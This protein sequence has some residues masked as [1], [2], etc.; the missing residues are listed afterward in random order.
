LLVAGCSGLLPG[1]G[2]LNEV[3][4]NERNEVTLPGAVVALVVWSGCAGCS[5]RC[6]LVWFDPGARCSGRWSGL[7]QRYRALW[8]RWWSG[9]QLP[10][11]GGPVWSPRCAGDATGRCGLV[12]SLRWSGLNEVYRALWSRWLRLVWLRYRALVVTCCSGLVWSGCSLLVARCARCSG[13]CG[14]VVR[15]GHLVA[16]VTL[17]GARCARC[18]GGLVASERALPVAGGPVVAFSAIARC[19]SSH[20]AYGLVLSDTLV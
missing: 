10:V 3:T 9:D 19:R 17:P 16:L 4:S 7:N 15:S 12:T 11:A 8:S 6:G 1:A 13:R 5:G 14:L 2:G 20:S 18:A